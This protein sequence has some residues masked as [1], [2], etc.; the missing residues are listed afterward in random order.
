[1]PTEGSSSAGLVVLFAVLI[2]LFAVGVIAWQAG[3]FDK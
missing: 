2:L 1:V 3:V